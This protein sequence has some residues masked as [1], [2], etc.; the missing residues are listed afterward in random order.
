[1]TTG[2]EEI[3]ERIQQSSNISRFN[4]LKREIDNA[5]DG[6]AVVRKWL[7]G[8]NQLGAKLCNY[9]GFTYRK[10][11]H[12]FKYSITPLGRDSE[13]LITKEKCPKTFGKYVFWHVIYDA[14]GYP[15]VSEVTLHA[16]RRKAKEKVD[17]R[18]RAMAAKPGVVREHYLF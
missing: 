13:G 11:S 12:L 17:A 5:D 1:V 9:Y 2:I 3:M 18:W 7:R 6:D 4:Q 8:G 10:R 16:T 15:T 14:D